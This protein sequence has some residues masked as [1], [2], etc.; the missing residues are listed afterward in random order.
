MR[1]SLA[2]LALCG[3]LAGCQTTS[4]VTTVNVCSVIQTWTK[5]EQGR[6]QVE[7]GR[8]PAPM[9]ERMAAEWINLRDQARACL[10]RNRKR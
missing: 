7:L 3:L 2:L 6:L 5:E 10:A 8:L 4:S 1:Q 9:T